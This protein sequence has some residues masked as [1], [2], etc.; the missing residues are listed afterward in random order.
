MNKDPDIISSVLDFFSKK[1]DKSIDNKKKTKEILQIEKGEG[2][3][4]F[5]LV[6]CKEFDN[7]SLLEYIDSHLRMFASVDR[8]KS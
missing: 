3:V 6:M 2:K 1:L 4:M 7:K 8:E 5:Y